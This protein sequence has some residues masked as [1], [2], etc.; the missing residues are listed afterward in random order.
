MTQGWRSFMEQLLKAE[1]A[2]EYLRVNSQTIRRWVRQGRLRALW[3]GRQYVFRREDLDA[4]LEPAGAG[5]GR[6]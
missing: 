6:T 3:S 2:A 1:E 5:H 4:F